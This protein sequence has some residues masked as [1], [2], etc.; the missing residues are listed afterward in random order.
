[1]HTGGHHNCPTS[2]IGLPTPRNLDGGAHES[3]QWSGSVAALRRQDAIVGLDHDELEVRL[4]VRRGIA[5]SGEYGPMDGA[6]GRVSPLISAIRSWTL[7]GSHGGGQIGMAEA[8]VKC[9]G[10]NLED[11]WSRSRGSRP[12]TVAACDSFLY[13]IKAAAITQRYDVA[14]PY[15][16]PMTTPLSRSQSAD[17]DVAAGPFQGMAPQP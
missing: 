3:G 6:I 7:L 2:A 17:A 11:D 13:E 8:V 9:G 5:A 12:W 14:A 10:V 1:L 15:M 4:L 16:P